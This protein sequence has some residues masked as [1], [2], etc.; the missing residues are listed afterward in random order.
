MTS[1]TPFDLFAEKQY[2]EECGRIYPHCAVCQYFWPRDVLLASAKEDTVPLK[3][4]LLTFATPM[5]LLLLS[6]ILCN[7][8]CKNSSPKLIN[9]N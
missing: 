7:A 4:V 6:F 8:K 9:F 5:N 3:L 2:N 1:R